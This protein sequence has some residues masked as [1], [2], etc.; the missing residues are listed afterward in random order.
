MRFHIFVKTVFCALVFS[1]CFYSYL[2]KQN[3]VTELRIELPKIKKELEKL[4]AIHM[5]LQFQIEKFEHP[6]HLL[7]LLAQK[8]YSHL[9][10]PIS[11]EI[12]KLHEGLAMEEKV[13]SKSKERSGLS[14]AVGSH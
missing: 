8:N 1:L 3:E 7:E 10:L 5:G 2:V 4:Q 14:F 13:F 6:S 12:M 11:S 9:K